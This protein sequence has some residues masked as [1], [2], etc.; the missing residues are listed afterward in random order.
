MIKE[1]M[2]VIRETITR[3]VTLGLLVSLGIE[4]KLHLGLVCLRMMK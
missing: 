2:K 1:L 3:G 4:G